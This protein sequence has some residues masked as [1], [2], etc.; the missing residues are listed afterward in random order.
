MAVYFAKKEYSTWLCVE[1]Y[2]TTTSVC[3]LRLGYFLCSTSNSPA[4]LT[5]LCSY[6]FSTGRRNSSRNRLDG[7][8]LGSCN[9]YKMSS[10]LLAKYTGYLQGQNPTLRSPFLPGGGFDA[11]ACKRYLLHLMLLAMLGN[12]AT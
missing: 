10:V 7:V 2:G 9:S 11:V 3:A 4:S 5:C 12:L 6:L 1:E 8:S